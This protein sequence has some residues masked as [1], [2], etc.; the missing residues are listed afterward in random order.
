MKRKTKEQV[1]TEQVVIALVRP[2]FQ[3]IGFVLRVINKILLWWW[4]DIWLQRKENAALRDDIQAN[5]FFLYSTGEVVKEQWL[6]TKLLPFDYAS[7]C[8]LNG[9]ICFWFTRGQDDLAVMLSPR[10][11]PRDTHE[12]HIVIAALDSTDVREQKPARYLSDV[13]ELLRPRMDALND[14]FSE[15]RYPA[16]RESLSSIDR[17]LDVVRREAEW[18]LNRA[19]YH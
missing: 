12:L 19:L 16:F 10:H 2:I 5:L 6:K 4:L 11:D 13:A 15:S 3:G 9:P 8:I 17:D 14:A 7:V 18:Q 1:A